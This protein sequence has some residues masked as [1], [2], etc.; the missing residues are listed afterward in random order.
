[1]ID[2]FMW[3]LRIDALKILWRRD[4]NKGFEEKTDGFIL[5]MAFKFRFIH[6]VL[7]ACSQQAL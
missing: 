1:M 4:T 5:Y 3:H 6:V 7:P 2:F